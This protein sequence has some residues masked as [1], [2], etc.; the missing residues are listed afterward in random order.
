MAIPI[1]N[2]W[3][4]FFSN[5]HE[6]LGSSYERVILNAML[7]RVADQYGVRSVLESPSFG[8]TGISGINLLD[9]ADAGIAVTLEDDDPQRLDLVK[10]VW[11][12]LGR[13][14]T[15]RHNPDFHGLDWPDKAFD[16]SFSFSALWF[17]PNL[18]S[19]L[20][21]LSRVTGKVIFL[22]V[23]NRTGLGY[24][25][26]LKDYSAGKYPGLRIGNI[27][28][29]SIIS[30]LA[31]Q[32]WE[33]RSAGY[34]DCPPWPDIGMTK[35]EL[36]KKWF[37]RLP[38]KDSSAAKDAGQTISILGLYNGKDPCFA[39]RMKRFQWF[40]KL[41]P[42]AVKRIWAHHFHMVFARVQS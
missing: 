41:A 18:K 29:P 5:P 4:K 8:F 6:G 14:L 38:I 15:A 13:P 32:G 16:M 3:E 9:L 17:V 40:E 21:E 24:K 25:L 11:E 23:P 12:R 19:W 27:D 35:E 7:R 31:S 34:F 26:Q 33:L 20:A 22:S 30:L 42:V 2:A 28:P 1:I 10:E 37:P 36:L 39:Y